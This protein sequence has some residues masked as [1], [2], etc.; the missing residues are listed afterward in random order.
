M[1]DQRLTTRGIDLPNGILIALAVGAFSVSF[2]LTHHFFDAHFPDGLGEGTL[3][4]INSF[5]NC[6]SATFSAIS[7]IVGMPIAF[8]GI[9]FSTMLILGSIFPSDEFEDTN[10]F[11]AI[12]N[13]VGCLLLLVFSLVVLKTLCPFCTLYY[14]LSWGILFLFWKFGTLPGR[15][16]P[17]HLGIAAVALV[18]GGY[19]FHDNFKTKTLRMSQ[20]SDSVVDEFK[21]LSIMPE[22]PQSEFRIYSSTPG[23]KDAPIQITVWS[24]FQCPACKAFSDLVP[25]LIKKYAG[26]MNIQYFPYPL[27]DHCNPNMKNAL[28]EMACQAAKVSMCAP[29]KFESTHERLFANQEKIGEAY[30]AELTQELGVQECIKG[31]EINKKI[32]E[33][34]NLGQTYGLSSTPTLL[35]NGRK[36]EGARPLPIMSAIFDY[37]LAQSGKN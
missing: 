32:L 23:F 21:K 14:V 26:K 33:G 20:M 1:S 27:D 9:I 18:V 29:A 25:D 17:L 35:V 7:N 10:G 37:L 36:I 16:A 31:E 11:L 6:D 19:F 13:G 4:N 12:I 28:H 30:L 8:L 15:P 34:I 2:Y 24:D 22:I 3:C 5:L